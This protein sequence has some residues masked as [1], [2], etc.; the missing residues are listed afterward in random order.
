MSALGEALREAR[1]GAGASQRALARRSGV[2][3]A[4]VSRIET[5]RESPSFERFA[6]LLSCLG[7]E[8]TIEVR[9]MRVRGDPVDLELARELT[10]SER[11]ELGFRAAAFGRALRAGLVSALERDA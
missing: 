11:V 8:A 7:L 6:R 4:A 5:G 10:P 3:Q 2:G 9:P 1:A